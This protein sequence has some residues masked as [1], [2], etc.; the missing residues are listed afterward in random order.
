MYTKDQIEKTVKSKGYVWFEDPKD[1]G[2]VKP[3]AQ[4]SGTVEFDYS[5]GVN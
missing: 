3:G 1:K 5:I 2:Y 4:T